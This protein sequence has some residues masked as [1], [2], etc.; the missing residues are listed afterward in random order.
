MNSHSSLEEG[1]SSNEIQESKFSKTW[2]DL[3]ESQASLDINYDPLIELVLTEIPEGWR[4]VPDFLIPPALRK[5][6]GS[7][8][9]REM[10][11]LLH[12]WRMENDDSYMLFR[13]TQEQ[14]RK[15]KKSA[16]G[17]L[18]AAKQAENLRNQI[19]SDDR[20]GCAQVLVVLS[21]VIGVL[22]DK[23]AKSN[24]KM[25]AADK[26]TEVTLAYER[27]LS[28]DSDE[29][30]I[31]LADTRVIDVIRGAIKGHADPWKEKVSDSDTDS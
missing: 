17:F 15:T 20:P 12:E 22:Y 5:Q 30:A 31:K 7:G 21:T 19:R 16:S 4:E 10:R 2:A 3:V 13:R 29:K 8:K 9:Y 23:H 28:S 25:R 11:S 26:V 1:S 24:D 6:W 27:L 18:D 14:R